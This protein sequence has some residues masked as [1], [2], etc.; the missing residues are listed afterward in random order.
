MAHKDGEIA[1]SKASGKLNTLMVLSTISTSSIQEV[2][3]ASNSLKWFQLYCTK[4]RK[5]TIDL[6]KKAEKYNYKAIVLT[7][8]TP[9]L[10]NRGK[11][12]FHFF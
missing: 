10:G 4:T 12:I 8:D 1:T 11:K 9:V 3:E 5:V 2:S 7:V 6:I